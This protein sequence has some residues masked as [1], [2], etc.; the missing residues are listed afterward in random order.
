MFGCQRQ[1]AN[2][3]VYSIGDLKENLDMMIIN[4][5]GRERNS[6]ILWKTFAKNMA[7]K[8]NFLELVKQ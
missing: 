6:K 4:F 5:N 1:T 8:P 7:I 2:S 3:T